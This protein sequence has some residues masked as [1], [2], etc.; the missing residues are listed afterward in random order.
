MRGKWTS[1]WAPAG[2]HA[3][4]GRAAKSYHSYLLRVLCHHGFGNRNF[5]TYLP[6][7]KGS[8][9]ATQIDK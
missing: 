4:M 3:A 8:E 9:H 6:H 1:D 2:E 5:A 7:L